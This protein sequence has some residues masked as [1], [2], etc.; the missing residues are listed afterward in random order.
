MEIGNP[1]KCAGTYTSCRNSSNLSCGR[2][3]DLRRLS[4]VSLICLNILSDSSSLPQLTNETFLSDACRIPVIL[5]GGGT[6]GAME[7]QA[8]RATELR[9][10]TETGDEVVTD[11][12]GADAPL[13]VVGRR[14]AASVDLWRESGSNRSAGRGQ[15][16][17][18]PHRRVGPWRGFRRR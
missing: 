3:C 12:A 2:L 10:C 13:I 6:L 8:L 15:V 1:T 11:L 14:S 9:Y 4:G 16:D 7:P 5:S 18:R 17:G